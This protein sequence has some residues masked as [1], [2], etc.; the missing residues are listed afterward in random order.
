MNTSTT[1]TLPV[2]A[3]S[4]NTV[5]EKVNAVMASKNN[6]GVNANIVTHEINVMLHDETLFTKAQRPA[7]LKGINKVLGT[8]LS[9]T[10]VKR[11]VK[12]LPSKTADSGQPAK[13]VRPRMVIPVD[14]LTGGAKTAKE[15]FAPAPGKI[16]VGDENIPQP[17]APTKDAD[18][19]EDAN[20]GVDELTQ[21][22]L[23]MTATT[24]TPSLVQLIADAKNP[25][26]AAASPAAAQIADVA[27]ATAAEAVTE[28]AA[29]A[30]ATAGLDVVVEKTLTEKVITTLRG[31]RKTGFSSGT[32]AAASAL[33]GSSLE[34]AFRGSVSVGSGLGALAGATGAYFAGEASD[35]LMESETGRYIVA[36]S[37]GTIFG[38]LGSRI[39][40]GL[41]QVMQSDLTVSEQVQAILPA[42]KTPDGAPVPAVEL[43]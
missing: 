27:S 14:G 20:T 2:L 10:Q 23:I 42:L 17:T 37:I 1:K 40:S 7:A 9:M 36:G 30:I 6:I 24:A 8:K 21:E 15:Y 41:Q 34:M 5:V 18:P 39:G 22:N 25:A 33:V 35:K 26:A 19:I 29:D 3:E 32:V 38:A 43:F 31:D 16:N 11:A 28:F 12:P 13:P 4:I